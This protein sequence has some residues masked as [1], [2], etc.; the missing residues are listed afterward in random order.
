MKGKEVKKI[1]LKCKCGFGRVGYS[2]M[3]VSSEYRKCRYCG[4]TMK[5]MKGGSD[6]K[7]A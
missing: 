2:D 6:E 3:S 5:E 7:G 4:K 1:L